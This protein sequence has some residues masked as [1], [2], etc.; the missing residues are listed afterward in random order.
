MPK[1]FCEHQKKITEHR[2]WHWRLLLHNKIYQ[3]QSPAPNNVANRHSGAVAFMTSEQTIRKTINQNAFLSFREHSSSQST[4]SLK[5]HLPYCCV[6]HLITDSIFLC[7][8]FS[9]KTFCLATKFVG[10]RK[11]F[12]A[13]C[14]L[15]CKWLEVI[16]QQD[17]RV[18][19]CRLLFAQ[20]FHI[21]H[22]LFS[23]LLLIFP[24]E[25]PELCLRSTFPNP[26]PTFSC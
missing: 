12:S 8:F 7:W 5:S 18:V 2:L 20:F 26:N 1:K 24:L 10:K 22:Y 13:R 6:F 19:R 9:R 15:V 25:Q 17:G 14:W 3:H 11:T 23:C 21:H 4:T 16:P